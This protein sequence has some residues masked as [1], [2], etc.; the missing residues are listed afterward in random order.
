MKNE[1]G[2]EITYLVLVGLCCFSVQ[3][4]EECIFE[5]LVPWETNISGFPSRG[6]MGTVCPSDIWDKVFRGNVSCEIVIG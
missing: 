1:M 2:N 5:E 3:C 6:I 4:L